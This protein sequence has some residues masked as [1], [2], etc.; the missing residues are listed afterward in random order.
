MISEKIFVH[1]I[2]CLHHPML[3]SYNACIIQCLQSSICLHHQSVCIINMLASSICLHHSMLASFNACIVQCLHHSMLA[4]PSACIIQCLYHP[5]LAA[6]NCATHLFD[7]SHCTV[8]NFLC[9]TVS[10]MVQF[11]GQILLLYGQQVSIGVA[12]C[13]VLNTGPQQKIIDCTTFS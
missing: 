9:H 4:S 1:I 5:M 13:R 3:A 2:Q 7:H 12:A 10:E 8:N 6:L 11:F